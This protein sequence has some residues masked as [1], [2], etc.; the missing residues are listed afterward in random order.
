MK[1]PLYRQTVFLYIHRMLQRLRTVSGKNKLLLGGSIIRRA[2]TNASTRSV[3]LNQPKT[4]AKP[5]IPIDPRM[6][7]RRR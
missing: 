2:I 7:R 5:R 1:M 3:R 6:V 4:Q